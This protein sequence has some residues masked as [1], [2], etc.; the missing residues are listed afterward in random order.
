MHLHIGRA[1]AGTSKYV[2]VFPGALVA[3]LAQAPCIGKGASLDSV[4]PV[5]ILVF[6]HNYIRFQGTKSWRLNG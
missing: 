1:L 6:P 3:M 5:S 2:A 4:S